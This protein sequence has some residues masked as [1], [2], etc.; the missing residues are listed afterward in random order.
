MADV[1]KAPQLGW[2]IDH[3][4]KALLDT[5]KPENNGLIL[6]IKNG[7]IALATE[8]ELFTISPFAPTAP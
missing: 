8:E 6:Y 5:E 4:L 2:Q 3:D 1:I 7:E